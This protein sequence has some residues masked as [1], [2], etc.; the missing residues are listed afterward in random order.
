MEGTTL[1]KVAAASAGSLG[2]GAGG[3]YYSGILSPQKSSIKDLVSRNKGIRIISQEES[4]RW[5]KAWTR[6]KEANKDK[7][8]DLWGLEGWKKT[9]NDSLSSVL[10]TKCLK[11]VGVEVADENDSRY[12]SFIQWCTRTTEIQ[13]Q[14]IGEGYTPISQTGQDDKWKINFDE[15]KKTGNTIKIHSLTI[16]TGDNKD[17]ADHL[18]KL[19]NGCKSALEAPF[20]N[21][22]YLNSL[23][24]I[25]KWCAT[26]TSVG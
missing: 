5:S 21:Q 11:E 4:E 17:T 6:Y 15:Y 20:N 9:D 18:N 25:K 24:G 3:L 23:E 2:A 13:D 7:D 8:Q 19:K 14:L 22:D 26:K 10:K 1:A 12:K 16:E